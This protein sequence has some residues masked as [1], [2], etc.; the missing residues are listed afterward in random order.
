MKD[1]ANSFQDK[2]ET[3]VED[4]FGVLRAAQAKTGRLESGREAPQKKGVVAW[5]PMWSKVP[6]P[7]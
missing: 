3:K 7:Q 5:M 1:T 2:A 4:M 6:L